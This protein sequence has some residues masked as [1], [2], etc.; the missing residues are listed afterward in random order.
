MT[1]PR[2]T[3]VL[4]L[5]ALSAVMGLL[6]PT[7]G[8]APAVTGILGVH[9]ELRFASGTVVAGTGV[10]V[11][12]RN[13]DT[14]QTLTLAAY[15][16]P[17]TSANYQA[18]GVPEGRY[19]I[20]ATRSGFATRYWPR[21]YGSAS[22]SPVSVGASPGCDPTGAATC[23]VHSLGL[24]LTQPV[25]LTGTVR[26]RAGVPV[27]AAPV[28]ATR[29]DEP[30]YAPSTTTGADGAYALRVPVGDYTLS[31]P[32]G[33]RKAAADLS[34]SG[35]TA[36]D[37]SLLD[38]PGVPGQAGA[39]AGNRMAT[40]SWLPPADD[41][42]AAVDS[43]TVTAVPGYATCTTATTT[44]TVDGLENGRAYRFTVEARNAVGRGMQATTAEVTPSSAAPQAPGRVRATGGDR[45]A[46][47]TWSASPSDGVLEYTATASPG[48]RSCSTSGL[49]CVITGLRN[50]TRY[51]VAVTAR[52]QGGYSEPAGTA[53]TPATVPGAPRAVRTKAG[54]S[55]LKVAWRAPRSD[56]GNRI[57]EYVAT[58]YPGGRTCRTT[59]ALRCT[60]RGL[61]SGTAFSI[62]VR[63]AN[64]AGA[65]PSSPGSAPAQP[66]PGPAAPAK[67]RGLRVR[68][69]GARAV[70]RWRPAKRA[71]SYWVR[72]D[73]G[74]G[75]GPWTLARKT[76]TAF[77]VAAGSHRVQVRAVGPGGKGPR[78]TRA[79]R[80]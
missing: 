15:G 78:A 72:L 31:T 50:G 11:V 36:R 64:R 48:G 30:G 41:G 58:A 33:D 23:D 2:R 9:I 71:R 68:V 14:G 1:L 55:A 54:R 4:A 3:T 28:T 24:E 75:Y 16:D 8:P 29:A 21:Q 44:C 53:V 56:G 42:G 77:A 57:R 70:V 32:N 52:S 10:T 34:V 18:L 46:E 51:R 79:F 63:A 13:L 62:T 43:Y 74:T 35:P 22:A 61:R 69:D 26:T 76:R 5:L 20:S 60:I 47:V 12:A 59:G 73:S 19:V 7:A 67:V 6:I 25:L 45:F 40:V 65:G 49:G 80:R 38:P 37:L 17:A 39:R 66:Q 27:A